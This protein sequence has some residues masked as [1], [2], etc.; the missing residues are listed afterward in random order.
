MVLDALD[1]QLWPFWFGSEHVNSGYVE[2]RTKKHFW[3]ISTGPGFCLFVFKNNS[4]FICF[5]LFDIIL[6][7]NLFWSYYSPSPSPETLFIPTPSTVSSFWTK[8]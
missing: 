4:I 2:G 8:K 6:T 3:A 7:L 1:M 5:L